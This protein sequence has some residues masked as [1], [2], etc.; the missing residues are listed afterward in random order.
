MELQNCIETRRSIRNFSDE[1]VSDEIL[2]ELVEAAKF[3]PSWKNTQV[4]RYYAVKSSDTKALILDAMPDFNHPAVSTAPVIIISSVVKLR[5]GYN[6]QGEFDSPKGKGWQMYD[7]GCS[8]MLFTLKANELGLGTV[9]M[10][11]YDEEKI[12]HAINLPESEEII[13]VIALGY[14]V[15]HPEMP[16]RKGSD[17]IL[18]VL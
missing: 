14:P 8:N 10:G 15:E 11:L 18:K 5:S 12:A 2:T 17:V 1:A 13:S 9:I 3:A 7:C 6:R 4:T 16:K